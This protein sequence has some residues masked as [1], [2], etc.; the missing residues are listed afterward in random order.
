MEDGSSRTPSSNLK[1]FGDVVRHASSDSTLPPLASLCEQALSF[2]KEARLQQRLLKNLGP[3]IPGRTSVKQQVDAQLAD[4]RRR[5]GILSSVRTSRMSA[6]YNACKSDMDTVSPKGVSGDTVAACGPDMEII[7]NCSIGIVHPQVMLVSVKGEARVCMILSVYL[8]SIPRHSSLSTSRRTNV[9]KLTSVPTPASLVACV[10]V[11]TMGHEDG[12]W[13]HATP[14]C[15]SFVLPTT[16]L[17]VR[18]RVLEHKRAPLKS[19]FKFDSDSIQTIAGALAHG[20]LAVA[21]AVAVDPRQQLREG[22]TKCNTITDLWSRLSNLEVRTVCPG[23]VEQNDSGSSSS[24]RRS[25]SN[26]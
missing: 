13:W 4:L 21:V 20:L 14:Y 9:R 19:S 16:S 24:R 23:N 3:W 5:A 26:M 17:R 15:P 2:L 22:F 18:L 8:R 7:P 1:T 12:V 25:S 10:R 6:W 11:V